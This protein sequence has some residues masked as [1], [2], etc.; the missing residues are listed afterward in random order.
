MVS[1][2]S[3][4]PTRLHGRDLAILHAMPPMVAHRAR[5]TVGLAMRT[6]RREE[7]AGRSAIVVDAGTA[8][9]IG[10]SLQTKC[11]MRDLAD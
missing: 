2:Q 11:A 3:V 4:L 10:P 1:D 6:I 8:A 9:P 7:L 5:A